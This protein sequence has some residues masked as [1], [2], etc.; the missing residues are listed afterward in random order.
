M[1]TKKV[2]PILQREEGPYFLFL[3]FLGSFHPAGFQAARANVHSLCTAVD[4]AL[5]ASYVGIPNPVGS[6]M[7]M[8]YVVTEMSAFATNIAFC[9]VRTSSDL[10]CRLTDNSSMIAEFRIFGKQNFSNF[11]KCYFPYSIFREKRL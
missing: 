9:H 8:A 7:G 10:I 5:Y 3:V 1:K 2:W 6:S 11:L 4:L